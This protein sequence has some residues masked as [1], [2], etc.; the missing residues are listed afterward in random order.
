MKSTNANNDRTNV[1]SN[2]FKKYRKRSEINGN[3][4]AVYFS[5]EDVRQVLRDRENEQRKEVFC[6][7]YKGRHLYTF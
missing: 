2:I 4:D 5:I 6:T 1:L 7:L 3:N